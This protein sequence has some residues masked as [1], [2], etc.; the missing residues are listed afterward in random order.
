MSWEKLDNKITADSII[1]LDVKT[2]REYDVTLPSSFPFN[3]VKFTCQALAMLSRLNSYDM[4]MVVKDILK[5]YSNPYAPSV[6]KHSRN[7]LRRIWRNK[8]PF[9]SYHYLIQ[10]EIVNGFIVIGDIF[11]DKQLHGPKGTSSHERTM[12]YEVNRLSN[13]RYN[14]ALKENEIDALREAWDTTTPSPVSNIKTSH[15]AVNGM[16]NELAKATWL[17]GTHV[18]AAYRSDNIQAYTLFHNPS[19]GKGLDGIECVF[20]KT[21]GR[22]THNAQHLASVLEQNQRQG[23]HVK[24]VAHSQ[25]AIIF[26][27][28]LQIYHKRN[29]QTPLTTQQLAVHGSGAQVERLKNFAR[30]AGLKINSVRNNPFDVVPN[31]F[32]PNDLS[33]SSL[34]RSTKF[35][36]LVFGDDAGASPHTLPFLGLET[37]AEQLR[38]L[39]YRDQAKEVNRFLRQLPSGDRFYRMEMRKNPTKYLHS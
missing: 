38:M 37:Y 26:S 11:F 27:T 7:P 15:A 28:A 18:D 10:F 9:R 8:Y 19:D 30:Q 34:A 32:G 1:P 39:G 22:K 5:I 6:T 29:N 14:K 2:C 17:M 25:G 31:V 21:L 13:A 33:N 36:K 4:D 16:Q 20:D 3:R 35:G 24:W 12:L 23:K